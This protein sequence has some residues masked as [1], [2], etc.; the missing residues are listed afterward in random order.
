M[1]TNKW[2]FKMN[3]SIQKEIVLNALKN[4]V[5][6]PTVEYLYSV[7][8]KEY[9]TVGIATIY[10][11]L[12]KMAEQGIIKKI[13]GL[14]NS[15]HFDHNTFEHYHF[16]CKNCGKVVDISANVAPNLKKLAEK[17]TG[18]IINK[19]DITF[20]GLCAECIGKKVIKND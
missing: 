11:N 5:V 6:H 9:P 7:I 10:R 4:N 18:F 12:N 14:E 13:E 8:K 1:R 19:Y 17:E 3:Y 2:K 16:I 20:S 15:A